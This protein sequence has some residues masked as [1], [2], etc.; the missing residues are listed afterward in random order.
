MVVGTGEILNVSATENPDLFWGMKGA[1]VNFGAVTSVTYK[2]YNAT[3]NGYAMNADM[4]FDGSL[5]STIFKITRQMVQNQPAGLTITLSVGFNSSTNG[6]S[7]YV[8]R[9]T[10]CHLSPSSVLRTNT[11]NMLIP[12]SSQSLPTS[13]TLAP[14]QRANPSSSP[15]SH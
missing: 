14:S 12:S 7:Q 9:Q 6:V 8:P 15:T 13:S 1:G 11:L 5:N 4:T 2:V 3:N 10:L